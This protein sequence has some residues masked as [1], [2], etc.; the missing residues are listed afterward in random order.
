MLL[1]S[2]TKWGGRYRCGC[3]NLG[4]YYCHSRCQR[5][6]T[7]HKH[8]GDTTRHTHAARH[9]HTHTHTHRNAHALTQ[10]LYKCFQSSTN[11]TIVHCCLFYLSQYERNQI[12]PRCEYNGGQ[13][14]NCL[15]ISN[16]VIHQGVASE[17]SYVIEHTRAYHAQHLFCAY[18]SNTCVSNSKHLLCNILSLERKL[19]LSCG[20]NWSWHQVFLVCYPRWICLGHLLYLFALL[21]VCVNSLSLSLSLAL[22]LSSSVWHDRSVHP[23]HFYLHTHRRLHFYDA[24]QF[25]KK[26]ILK[27]QLNITVFFAATE[28]PTGAYKGGT[29]SHWSFVINVSTSSTWSP[30]I[31]KVAPNVL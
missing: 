29:T 4:R 17:A 30:P 22:S 26:Y 24:K 23:N 6:T 19:I 8:T 18:I 12:R 1:I 3:S 9:E 5:D 14:F 25:M 16:N 10:D 11:H 21:N 27:R 13:F 28:G 31:G 15:V 2:H 7:L 20:S